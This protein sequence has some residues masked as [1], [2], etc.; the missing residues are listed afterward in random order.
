M[1]CL[2]EAEISIDRITLREELRRR[3]KDESAGGAAYVAALTDGLPRGVNVGHYARTVREKATSRQLIQLSHELMSRCYEGEDRPAEILERAESQ[4]FRIA[5]R[6]M[7]DG[8]EPT[9]ELAHSIYKEIDL[10][11]RHRFR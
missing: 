10:R 1:L 8:F 11:D 6:E 3:D 7:R 9:R 2:I 4:I 5:S